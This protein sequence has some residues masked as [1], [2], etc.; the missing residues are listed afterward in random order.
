MTNIT[1]LL[2]LQ[3]LSASKFDIKWIV[4][5]KLLPF[6]IEGVLW[7]CICHPLPNKYV[8]IVLSQLCTYVFIYIYT[9]SI[10]YS[11]RIMLYFLMIANI[12]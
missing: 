11:D 10:M 4:S 7:V 12:S 9:Y 5:L 2:T 3:Y 8:Y 1:L 6:R